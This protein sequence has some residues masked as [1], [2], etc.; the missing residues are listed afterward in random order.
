M[1]QQFSSRPDR[2]YEPSQLPRIRQ[3]TKS[4]T[5]NNYLVTLSSRRKGR[6]LACGLVEIEIRDDFGPPAVHHDLAN[7]HELDL[8][9][10]V[11]RHHDRAGD[12][13]MGAVP[14]KA[15]AQSPSGRQGL[16]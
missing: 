9:R 16:W 14:I 10:I 13:G 5:Q 2:R 1:R 12:A 3:D 8:I 6:G 4:P 15:T 7:V 11:R